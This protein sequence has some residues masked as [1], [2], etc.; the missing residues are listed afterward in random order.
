MQRLS[1][2]LA[3]DHPIV[4]EG[5]AAFFDERPELDIV[6][7][8]SDGLEA[9]EM[10]K[11]LA[12]DFAIIDLQLPG[13]HGLEVIQRLRDGNSASKLVILTINHD[14]RMVLWALRAGADGYL[15]KMLRCATFST[16]SVTFRVAESTSRRYCG[17]DARRVGPL[18]NLVTHSVAKRGFAGEN[19]WCVIILPIVKSLKA[20]LLRPWLFFCSSVSYILGNNSG[21]NKSTS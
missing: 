13:L 2:V 9:V 7:Q 18:L 14:E 11:G 17:W 10:I 15:S 3:D 4:R 20:R 12:P 5:L 21:P 6:G 1:V 19:T 8:C 16:P